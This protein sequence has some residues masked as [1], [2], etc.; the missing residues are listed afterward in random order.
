MQ[1]RLKKGTKKTSPRLGLELGSVSSEAFRANHYTRE[2]GAY[3]NR[4]VK[5]HMQYVRTASALLR[6]CIVSDVIA[7][8]VPEW[9]HKRLKLSVVAGL[10]NEKTGMQSSQWEPPAKW[11]LRSTHVDSGDR[12]PPRTYHVLSI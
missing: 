8:K 6:S 3:V 12:G 4:K 11:L 9:P 5:S 2:M 7:R 10:Q 1:K